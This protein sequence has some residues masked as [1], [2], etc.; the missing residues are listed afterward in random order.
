MTGDPQDRPTITFGRRLLLRTFGRPEGLL[1]RLGGLVMARMNR[2]SAAWAIDLLEI[3]DADKVLEI[4]FGPGVAIQMLASRASAGLVVGVDSSEVM[5]QQA[6]ARN[7]EAL[8]RNCAMARFRICRLPMA[9]ST[10]LWR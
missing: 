5:V 7:A 3:Q 6:S 10:K 8:T 4:G 2:N 9:R 1:G